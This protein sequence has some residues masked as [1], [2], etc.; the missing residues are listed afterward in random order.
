MGYMIGKRRRKFGLY[1]S[2]GD[3]M[4]RVIIPGGAQRPYGGSMLPNADV[5]RSAED[6]N[7]LRYKKKRRFAL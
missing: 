2:P 3:S 6:S 1:K 7:E 4:D 5:A